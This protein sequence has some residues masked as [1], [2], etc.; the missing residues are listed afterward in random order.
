MTLH[1]ILKTTGYPVAEIEFPDNTKVNGA[2]LAPPFILYE[3]RPSDHVYADN[4]A[5]V[6]KD[7]YH[8]RLITAGFRPNATV[9]QTLERAFDVNSVVYALVD[10]FKVQEEKTYEM[11]Y[12]IEVLRP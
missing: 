10:A 11:I 7:V 2:P 1:Q 4:Q 6:K 3:P 9:R 5:Y 8:V 12:Q